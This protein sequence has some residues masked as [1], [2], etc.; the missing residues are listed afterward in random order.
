MLALAALISPSEAVEDLS[1]YNKD[2][3]AFV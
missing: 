1:E 3:I 2:A